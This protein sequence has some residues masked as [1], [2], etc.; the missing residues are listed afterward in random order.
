MQPN[1]SVA[2]WLMAVISVI[3]WAFWPTLVKRM[4]ARLRWELFYFDFAFSAL[5]ITGIAGLT[6]GTLNVEIPF[7]DNIAIVGYRQLAY[8]IIAGSVFNLGN[9]ML[10]GGISLAGMTVAGILSGS[11]ALILATIIGYFTATGG[12]SGVQFAG[13]IIAAGLFLLTARSYDRALMLRHRDLMHKT[14]MRK[15]VEAPS[16]GVGIAFCIISGVG[17]GSFHTFIDWA[18]VADLS[19]TAYPIAF[20]FAL[21]IFLS[22]LVFNLY[23]MNLPVQGDP[24]SP[25][26]YFRIPAGAHLSGILSGLVFGLGLVAFLLAAEANGAIAVPR[27]V[28]LAILPASAALMALQGRRGWHEFDDATY[29]TQTVLL[30]SSLALLLAAATVIAGYSV[31]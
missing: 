2:V 24:L 10:V 1:S 23:F 7:R 14:P 19:M 25:L 31:A 18:R 17:L 12:A 9:M 21:G 22:T 15:K 26:D 30:V 3:L 27:G 4:S 6:L 13:V 5:L 11:I 28:I 20:F 16:A 29:R 8:A